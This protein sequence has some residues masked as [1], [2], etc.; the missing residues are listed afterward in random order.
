MATNLMLGRL[1]LKQRSTRCSRSSFVALAFQAPS[2]HS[3]FPASSRRKTISSS[4]GT[5]LAQQTFRERTHSNNPGAIRSLHAAA[6]AP[7]DDATTTAAASTETAAATAARGVAVRP[8]TGVVDATSPIL[9]GLN[10][11][12]IEAVTQPMASVTRV[13]AGPGSGK[14]RVLTS[15]IAWLLQQ[16][17]RDRILGVTFTRKAS[18]E[19]QER[20]H[21]L[22]AEQE[23]TTPTATTASRPEVVQETVGDATASTPVGLDRVTLGTFHSIC[24]K[25][26]RWNGDH[27]ASLPSV[28]D[29]MSKS[30]SAPVL[31]G[32][33]NIADQGEQVRIVKECLAEYNIDLKPYDLKPLQVLNT[34]SQFKRMLSKGENPFAEPKD[35]TTYELRVVQITQKVYYRCREKLL[36]T[37]CIDFDDLIY[38]TRELLLVN[39]DL[40]SRLQN[41]WN[42]VLVDEYQDTSQTQ[43]DLIKLLTDR[44]LFVVGDADQSIYSWRGAH[45]GS[46]SDFANDFR[47]YHTDG[48]S[49]VYLMENYR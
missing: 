35:T 21:R 49:T 33:F 10:P 26:L 18:G 6:P 9:A 37:N 13:V 47:Q 22:L 38:L 27:L 41:R 8:T 36:S 24:A 7:P 2:P 4:G 1:V 19:M 34:V 32:N 43:M 28:I 39:D 17:T 20:L 45:V 30:P 3:L 5:E 42:H 23:Q 25:I 14:T 16:N 15:R 29:D 11:S 46:L 40:R 12:Q 31:D 48:V 44:S